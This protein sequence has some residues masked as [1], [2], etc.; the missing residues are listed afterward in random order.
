MLVSVS[1]KKLALNFDRFKTILIAGLAHCDEIGRK[2]T[3]IWL[4]TN[5]FIMSDENHNYFFALNNFDF[6]LF[7]ISIFQ[8]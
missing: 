7:Y 1:Y 6:C 4:N 5:T 8:T 2:R 3:M